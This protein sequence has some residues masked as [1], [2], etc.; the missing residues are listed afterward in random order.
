MSCPCSKYHL[1]REDHLKDQIGSVSLMLP[2]GLACKDMWQ[3]FKDPLH[4]DED[5][6][7]LSPLDKGVPEATVMGTIHLLWVLR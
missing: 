3:G 7:T 6:G 4:K 2:S 5:Q 1:K